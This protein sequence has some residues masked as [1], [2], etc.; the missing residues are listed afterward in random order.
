MSIR[1]RSWG[2]SFA[3]EAFEIDAI[4]PGVNVPVDVAKVI[5]FDVLAVFGEFLGE[6]EGRGAVKA[7]HEAVDHSFGDEVQG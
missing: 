4:R 1:I 2:V 6:A 3:F 5:A 7:G